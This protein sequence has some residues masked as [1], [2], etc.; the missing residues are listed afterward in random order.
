M[1]KMPFILPYTISNIKKALKTIGVEQ[2]LDLLYFLLALLLL[3]YLE[4]CYQQLFTEPVLRL[5]QSQSRNIRVFVCLSVRSQNTHFRLSGHNKKKSR[6][7]EGLKLLTD[8]VNIFC[9]EGPKQMFKGGQF[10]FFIAGQGFFAVEGKF[11]EGGPKFYF[12]G[13]VQFFFLAVNFFSSD[14]DLVKIC[15]FFVSSR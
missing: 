7:Q 6:L 8:A 14:S 10:F 9:P 2:I 11:F 1:Y 4:A 13:G 3:I 5:I 12:L 15:I